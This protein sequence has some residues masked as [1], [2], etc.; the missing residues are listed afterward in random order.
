MTAAVILFSVEAYAGGG[1]GGGRGKAKACKG[2]ITGTWAYKRGRW[3]HVN[4]TG[5]KNNLTATVSTKRFNTPHS[6]TCRVR[7]NGNAVLKL[8]N[9]EKFVIFTDGAVQGTY[10][11]LA[12]T[13]SKQ[14]VEPDPDPVAHP[15]DNILRGTWYYKGGRPMDMD[16]RRIGGKRFSG[17]IYVKNGP[18]AAQGRCQYD[19]WA[20]SVTYNFKNGSTIT[21]HSDGSASG[22]Y[23][24][25]SYVGYAE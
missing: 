22:D 15:C 1:F 9:G 2:L 6:A 21:V 12:F 14:G 7:P 5:P 25:I 13:G 19:R 16:L 10:G 24:G 18:W 23:G 3:M 8:D 11:N 4:V 20:D 17:T